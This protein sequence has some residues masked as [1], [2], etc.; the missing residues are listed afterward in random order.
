MKVKEL[1]ALLGKLAKGSADKDAVLSYPGFME[2]AWDTPAIVETK[3]NVFIVPKS[4][5][6]LVEEDHTP[7]QVKALIQNAYDS[8][9][10]TGNAA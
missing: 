1:N 5:E 7:E 8:R 10:Q 2:D 3:N 6:D 4:I 9:N